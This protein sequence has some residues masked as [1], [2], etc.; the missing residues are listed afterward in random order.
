MTARIRDNFK[1]VG[2]AAVDGGRIYLDG[3]VVE[4]LREP[5]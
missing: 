2:I 3:R 4:E 5:N 1:G